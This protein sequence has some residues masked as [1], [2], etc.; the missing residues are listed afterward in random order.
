MFVP[1]AKDGF[2]PAKVIGY[3]MDEYKGEEKWDCQTSSNNQAI[4]SSNYKML[5]LTPPW[6]GTIW[7]NLDSLDSRPPP[8]VGTF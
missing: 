4:V 6:V 7:A 3:E 2:V 5:D 1:D 8:W